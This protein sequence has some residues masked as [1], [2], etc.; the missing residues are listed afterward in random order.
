MC[1]YA[2]FIFFIKIVVV[3]PLLVDLKKSPQTN[4]IVL[5]L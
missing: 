5:F 2:Y 3:A 4:Y 1:I